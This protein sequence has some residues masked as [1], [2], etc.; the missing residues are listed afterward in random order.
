[1][2]G[3]DEVYVRCPSGE[4][5]SAVNTRSEVRI[6]SHAGG[7]DGVDGAEGVDGVTGGGGATTQ[8]DVT[9]STT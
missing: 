3:Y 4:V 5:G 9:A 1:V 7:V 6:W 8:V 2:I